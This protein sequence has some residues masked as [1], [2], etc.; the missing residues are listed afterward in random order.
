ML[1]DEPSRSGRNEIL[2]S[3]AKRVVRDDRALISVVPGDA[4][5]G[6]NVN[7]LADVEEGPNLLDQLACQ[8]RGK[9]L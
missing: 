6:S 4:L 7:F 3:G 5:A 9:G 8:L 2:C 1:R